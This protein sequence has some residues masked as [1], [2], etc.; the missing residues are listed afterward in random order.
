MFMRLLA[1]VLC[2]AA[3]AV[4]PAV[5]REDTPVF[6]N[7]DAHA[8]ALLTLTDSRE[9][10]SPGASA[11][12]AY[13]REQLLAAGL[14]DDQL[15]E[16][17]T[18][19][20][21]AQDHVANLRVGNFD[22]NGI[23]L[24]GAQA[25]GG[26]LASTGGDTLTGRLIYLGRGTTEDLSGRGHL[27][28]NAI[29]LL[30]GDSHDAW[31]SCAELGAQAV[32]FR[33]PELMSR[34][35]TEAHYVSASI[36]FPRFTATIS[37]AQLS[38]IIGDDANPVEAELT[39]RSTMVSAP[40]T[41][42]VARITSPAGT[43]KDA[44]VL[45][46]G[47]EA[48]GVVP[49]QSP[50]ATR[51]WNAGLLLEVARQ[52]KAQ[53]PRR[54]VLIVFHG[55]RQEYFR[56]LRQL[57][58][59]LLETPDGS[60][61]PAGDRQVQELAIALDQARQV[62]SDF[63][64]F[65]ELDASEQTDQRLVEM[66]ETLEVVE[67]TAAVAAADADEPVVADSAGLSQ[68][69][70]A[71]IVLLVIAGLLLAIQLAVKRP[72][73]L[74]T[75]TLITIALFAA[76]TIQVEQSTV[77]ERSDSEMSEEI[78]ELGLRFVAEEAGRRADTIQPVL[79]DLR[80]FLRRSDSV[81]DL[82]ARDDLNDYQRQNLEKYRTN[83]AELRSRILMLDR[84]LGRG[85]DLDAERSVLDEMVT[86]LRDESQL[87]RNIQLRMVAGKALEPNESE[88]LPDLIGQVLAERADGASN[89]DRHLSVLQSRYDDLRSSQRIRS[90]LSRSVTN[91]DGDTETVYLRP[92]F[93]V[94]LDLTDGNV[95][96]STR[97]SGL[98]WEDT[99]RINLVLKDLAGDLSRGSADGERLAYDNSPYE[100]GPTPHSYWPESSY[101]ASGAIGGMINAVT[102]ATVNDE[103]LRLGTPQDA[104]GY[105]D[106]A[107]A[108]VPGF[109]ANAFRSQLTGLTGF[110]RGIIRQVETVPDLTDRTSTWKTS[111]VEL[112]VK[113]QSQ[114][115]TTG[116]KGYPYPAVSL[117]MDKTNVGRFVGD[118][119][120]MERYWG[121]AFGV[122][123]FPWMPSG[124]TKGT[125][126]PVRVYGYSPTGN[127][128]LSEVM[129]TIGNETGGAGEVEF[130]VDGNPKDRSIRVFPSESSSLFGIY[131]PRLMR[132]LQ[133]VQLLSASKDSEP[134][135][136]HAESDGG[137]VALFAPAGVRLRVLAREGQIGNRMLLLGHHVR[138]DEFEGLAPGGMLSVE[139]AEILDSDSGARLWDVV[140]LTLAAARDMSQINKA[141]L[142]NLQATGI[143][144]EDIWTLKAL[145][146][147]NLDRA[148]EALARGDVATARGAAAAAWAYES[149]VYPAV[150]ATS[151]DV[152]YGL[153]VMLL[154]AIPFAVICERLF[155]AGNTIFTKLAGFSAFFIATF[156]FF[157]N[158]H[159][160]FELATTPVIIF[161]AFTIIVMSVLVI[162]II[163]NRFEYEMESI[164]MAGL[165]MHKAD[166]T[167]L[168]T[169]LATGTLGISNMRRRP[170]RTFLTAITVVLMTFILLTFASFSSN[171]GTRPIDLKVSPTYDGVLLRS[172]VWGELEDKTL[173]RVV[174]TWGDRFKAHERR[175]LSATGDIA[176]FPFNNPDDSERT[177]Y[178]EGV[179]G[180]ADNDPSGVED[181]LVRVIIDGD[182]ARRERGFG[183]ERGW[184][185]LPPS[186]IRDV[187][188]E[189][190]QQIR[191][192][193]LQLRV[194][195][196]DGEQ[197]AGTT[198]LGGDPFTPLSLASMT[199]DQKKQME[200]AA[201]QTAA[202]EVTGSESSS[203]AHLGPESVAVMHRDDLQIIGGSIR[204]IA[205]LPYTDEDVA[206]AASRGV[207]LVP[208]DELEIDAAAED[209]AQQLAASLRVGDG[210]QTTLLTAVGQLAVSGLADVI[211]PL[212]LGGLI[213]FS[214]MLGSVAERGREIFIYASLGLAP[215]HIAALFL[216]E[217]GIYAVIGGMS[218]YMLA[219]LIVAA[220]GLAADLG[221]G[222]QPDINYSSFTAVI[223]ILLVMATVLLSAAYPA[224]VASRS[225]RP[226]EDTDFK[227][228]EPDGDVIDIPFPFTV[229]KRDILGLLAFLKTYFDANT[230]ASVG[231]FTAADA[232]MQSEGDKHVVTAKNWLAP[233]DLGIS[234]SFVMTAAPTD[235]RAIFS[236]HIRLELLSGQ[237]SAW[238]RVTY[239]F[240]KELRK[241][242]LV[243]RTLDD[244]TMDRYRAAGG[245]AEAAARQAERDA[246]RQARLAEDEQAEKDQ[247]KRMQDE[248]AARGGDAEAQA[249]LDADKDDQGKDEQGKE[250]QA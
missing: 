36:E 67:E 5:E 133:T 138:S 189:A 141:R 236:I 203:F 176:R 100:I 180:T 115:S 129:A 90:A 246:A 78:R 242:F 32:I 175:W 22:I 87:W 143:N 150:L 207:T 166:V 155:V 201:Q 44:V 144:P 137:H 14:S 212:V 165:G 168:G 156:L 68:S 96:F 181:A 64:A 223:T 158:F 65:L 89:V 28:R 174:D 211:I 153:V 147:A 217:A 221:F 195:E 12:V 191:F 29:V 57:V 66:L 132:T 93:V 241:Q 238:R 45:A 160:A 38:E 219:Q 248:L 122:V 199:E 218:G 140:P 245:D 76:R 157:Y 179:I 170:L 47:Y 159:P 55:A 52:L 194:G 24:R 50:G 200:A 30:D 123:T 169:L 2:L 206:M 11:A 82:S 71:I 73:W 237:R 186:L 227:V 59:T 4:V 130:G 20:L 205:L 222:V 58:K 119:R 39:V 91:A 151:N 183:G 193:G 27:L 215:I 105:S 233:F 81:Q 239:P 83:V 53:P 225:A 208:G 23:N 187:G 112:A 110:V 88:Q 126:W 69:T 60:S 108:V 139:P 135:Y 214:T 145:G 161:L 8:R 220:L 230:E 177:G 98:L 46:A 250:G 162:M 192:R 120:A 13:L 190:G 37:D 72:G 172:P 33:S 92:S 86:Q 61:P 202:G 229:A 113:T 163:Y 188:L 103:R 6:S 102:I 142:D 234:Q 185:F 224:M 198:H 3:A 15:F 117:V 16:Q 95:F 167:R 124:L 182:N 75:W 173:D 213:I 74:L 19:V 184:I 26:N 226:G 128:R 94:S 111:T 210:G 235:V 106:A 148:D 171:A 118:V 54:D 149:R 121:D 79:E 243:W 62:R 42:L 247:K 216:V 104:G 231:C 178:V 70:V 51:A 249:R 101:H 240:L 136:G 21:V 84:I 107:G 31:I 41:T 131:D 127:G 146:K 63:S 197:L 152:V 77:V 25:N 43:G 35:D 228:P 40:S 99:S 18:T 125:K 9:A 164:R 97:T 10:G 116:T 114:G 49:G 209:M 154:L 244:E 7:I 80:L 17:Q 196:L 109:D 56:G 204:S 34:R 85:I 1:L 48:A 134:T 232:A